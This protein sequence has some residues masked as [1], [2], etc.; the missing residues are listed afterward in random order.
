MEALRDRVRQN[1]A[2]FERRPAARSDLRQAAVALALL[3]DA[4]KRPC[5]LITRR[6]A[7]MRQ[8]PGQFAL[9]GGRLDAGESPEDAA[10]REMDEEVG[11]SLPRESVLGRL[12]DYVTRSGYVITPVVVWS[13]GAADLTPNPDEVATALLVPLAALEHPDVPRLRRIP[14][15]TR[16]VISVPLDEA[17]GVAIH[18]PTA[19]LL[20]QLREVALHGRGT[21][22]AHYDAPVFAWS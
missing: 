1:L 18:A 22:V 12:D 20:F 16:P 9:P 15:T 6:A 5:F 21:R 8:H 4:R 2:R 7:R 13:P 10:L 19:A 11:L 14:E 17:L 3:P